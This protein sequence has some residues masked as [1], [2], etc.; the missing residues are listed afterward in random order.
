MLPLVNVS[1]ITNI[2][3]S[4]LWFFFHLKQH[5][6]LL[7]LCVRHVRTRIKSTDTPSATCKGWSHPAIDIHSSWTCS[8]QHLDSC[9]HVNHC[10]RG[11][12]SRIISLSQEKFT[13][14]KMYVTPK[15]GLLVSPLL[16]G[17]NR[18]CYNR[19]ALVSVSFLSL[20]A[21]DGTEGNR[22]ELVFVLFL[23]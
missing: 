23:I 1:T 18:T 16:R 7:S 8:L 5:N 11:T 22:T 21:V 13:S 6:L 12:L 9:C 17:W 20:H 10:W 19:S 14:L 4:F 3:V 15:I 2:L